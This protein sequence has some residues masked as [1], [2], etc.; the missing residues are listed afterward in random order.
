MA[1][2]EKPVEKEEEPKVEKETKKSKVGVQSKIY[3]T[4][5]LIV[6]VVSFFGS[7][8]ASSF[9]SVTIET[10]KIFYYSQ[11]ATQLSQGKGSL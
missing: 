9:S 3:F 10:S 6:F 1:E 4:S 7:L 8:L 5:A 2:D 11:L